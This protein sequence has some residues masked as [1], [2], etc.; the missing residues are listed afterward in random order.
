[1]G[2]DLQSPPQERPPGLAVRAIRAQ[3][4][5]TLL[6]GLLTVGILLTV[7]WL[8]SYLLGGASHVP[9]HWFYIPILLAAA[10]F[11]LRGAVG[12]AVAAG[13]LAGPLLPADVATQTAQS[14]AD[15]LSRMGFFVGIG[16]VMGAV[17]VGLMSALRREVGLAREA[18]HLAL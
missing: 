11:G 3:A 5:S 10:R 17:I 1:M 7:S 12:A 15:W 16:L 13:L 9:P 18:G 8:G 6:G 4:A 14:S 2:R